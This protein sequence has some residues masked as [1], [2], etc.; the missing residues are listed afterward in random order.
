MD[1]RDSTATLTA[2]IENPMVLDEPALEFDFGPISWVHSEID[3]SLKRALEYLRVFQTTPGDVL[4]LE[5]ARTHVHQVAGAIHMVGLEAVVAFTDEIE[6]HL[7]RL[8]EKPPKALQ[9]ACD[10]IERACNRLSIFL[11]DLADGELPI[12]LKLYPEYAALQAARGVTITLTDLFYP[13]LIA[14]APGTAPRES[15]AA[16]RLPSYLVKQRRLYQRGLLAW[17][18]GDEEG[19]R[20][21]RDAIASI[22]HVT[23]H[24]N[25]RSFWWTVGALF[26]AL[27][28]RGVESGS[29]VKQLAARV[30]LQIRRAVEGSAKA[31]DRLRRE[32]LYYVAISAPVG[33]Q[34]QAV[35]RAF[36][37]SGLV[38][39]PDM[40]RADAVTMRSLARSAR[41]QLGVAKDAWVKLASGQAESLDSLRDALSSVHDN[42]LEMN[43]DALATLTGSLVDRLDRLPKG[44]ILEPL[45]T[46][47]ATA[48]LLAE[49]ALEN[50]SKLA[51]NFAEQV[52][53]MLERLDAASAGR[54][55][56]SDGAQVVGNLN[57]RSLLVQVSREIHENLRHMEDVL[58]AFFR[59]N[60]K[61]A[62]LASL[63]EDIS[64]IRGALRILSLDGADRL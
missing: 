15:I 49:S 63:G 22:E 28:M 5:R 1:P 7:A 38:P 47:V 40:V 53:A 34:V 42:A 55:P 20:T 11:A 21:M 59:D 62:E 24:A 41:E 32:V 6:Q 8:P 36:R 45:A 31:A 4:A 12:P 17:L 56:T 44:E 14:C 29:G 23:T 58:D 43:R 2:T 60:N 57:K 18:G 27:A 26:E 61:R 10:V 51:P 37:L 3:E 64:Q 39:T 9:K 19:S 35:Q 30:D 33:P 46:E 48:L 54:F 25:L 52:A 13:D 50:R 16:N